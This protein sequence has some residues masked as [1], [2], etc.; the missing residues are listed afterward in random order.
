MSYECFPPRP[1]LLRN[2]RKQYRLRKQQREQTSRKRRQF[3]WYLLYYEEEKQKVTA[4]YM[5]EIPKRHICLH[6]HWGSSKYTTIVKPVPDAYLQQ[7]E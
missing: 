2:N 4:A 6:L 7:K 5:Q 3:L 1:V